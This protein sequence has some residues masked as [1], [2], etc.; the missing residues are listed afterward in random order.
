MLF[1]DPEQLWRHALERLRTRLD[2]GEFNNWLTPLRPRS[3][4]SDRLY[5]QVQNHRI[6][7]YFA[8][9][10]QA[11]LE[12][13]LTELRGSQ[14]HISYEISLSDMHTPITG[15]LFPAM[16]RQEALRDDDAPP[17]DPI[18]NRYR[19]DAFVV[20]PSN[21]MASAACRAVAERP[22]QNFNP[23]FIYGGT[24]L[25]KTHLLQ[26]VVHQISGLHPGLKVRYITCESYLND[27]MRAIRTSTMDLFRTRYRDMVDVLLV[28]DIQFL[29]GKEQTQMEFFHTFNALH[30]AG[31]QIILSSDRFPKEIPK[32]EDRL[33]SRFQWGL[34]A[35]IK[36]PTRETRIA[37]LKNK[38]AQDGFDLSDD[39]ADYIASNIT[40][41][42]RELESCLV[43][44]ELEAN[45][46]ASAI[47]L[48]TAKEALRTIIKDRITVLNADQII[49][50]VA[51]S[52]NV[53]VGDL[54]STSRLQTVTQPRQVAMYLC[55]KLTEH[56][57]PEIG[58]KFGGRDHS[59][60]YTSIKKVEKRLTQDNEFAALI[61]DIEMNLNS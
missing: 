35:D 18:I 23:L 42:V 6:Q 38:A 22:A 53:T 21:Q 24:G 3:L 44:L 40:T 49:S 27:F 60:V 37:I 30:S 12:T 55:R 47:T 20:G 39:V 28:D 10:Y 32:I 58:Q 25:G 29:G 46:S 8:E 26:A 4:D 16:E 52:F 56:S 33:K 45:L 31:K 15:E 41:N 48:K 61:H 14:V 59:T 2:P 19:F 13:I 17:G 43:R 36:P 54:K 51:A 9:H 1:D 7:E 34:I 50:A 11:E 5:L 57:F